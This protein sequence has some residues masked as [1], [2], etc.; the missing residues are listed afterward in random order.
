MVSSGPY[1]QTLRNKQS[2][3]RRILPED[4]LGLLIAE[5][6]EETFEEIEKRTREDEFQDFENESYDEETDNEDT[7]NSS[8]SEDDVDEEEETIEDK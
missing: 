2:K 6:E 7:D 4:V 5:G 3:G 1:I 8:G